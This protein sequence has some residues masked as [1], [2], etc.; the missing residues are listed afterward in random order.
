MKHFFSC[1]TYYC[2]V[3]KYQIKNSIYRLKYNS[4][5]FGYQIE[6]SIMCLI[7]YFK[8]HFNINYFLLVIMVGGF[9]IKMVGRFR[10]IN[11]RLRRFLSQGSIEKRIAPETLREERLRAYSTS[12]ILETSDLDCVLKADLM[13]NGK[14][15]RLAWQETGNTE[16]RCNALTREWLEEWQVQI[17]VKKIAQSKRMAPPGEYSLI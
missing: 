14:H 8:R 3:L 4:L 5:L 2:S 16:D 1:L 10:R 15:R 7:Y 17:R 13:N 6:L 11:R 12:K 9:A